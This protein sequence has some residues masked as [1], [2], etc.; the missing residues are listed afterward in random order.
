MSTPSRPEGKFWEWNKN[1]EREVSWKCDA[2]REN[3]DESGMSESSTHDRV[4]ETQ[5]KAKVK[6]QIE[7]MAAR[8]G[9]SVGL[10][11][12]APFALFEDDK[13]EESEEEK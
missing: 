12:F 5:S 8:P 3:C 11:R 10:S 7:E 2:S 1:S 9:P 4:T 13:M 6:K